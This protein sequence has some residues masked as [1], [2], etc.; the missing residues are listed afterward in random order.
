MPELYAERAE[1]LL[2]VGLNQLAMRD[3]RWAVELDPDDV[4]AHV[5]AARAAI[6]VGD[7]TE[8]LADLDMALEMQPEHGQAPAW[9]G[10]ALAVEG[11]R[12]AA[13]ASWARAEAVLPADDPLRDAI[14]TWRRQARRR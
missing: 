4:E 7:G 13:E 10:R 8:A 5:L 1:W 2:G 12:E 11:D 14:A 3:A 6:E 9:R